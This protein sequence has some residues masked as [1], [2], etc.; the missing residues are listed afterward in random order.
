MRVGGESRLH[1]D[2]ARLFGRG[3]AS[4]EDRV[5]LDRFRGDGDQAAFAVL[6]ERHGPMVLGV[7]RRRLGNSHD[8]DDAFQA[9]FLVLVRNAGRL[10]N[11]DRLGP[12]LY[13]VA[14]RVSGKAQ[15]RKLR[16]RERPQIPGDDPIAREGPTTDL[17]DVKP[18]LDAELARV[19][20]KLRDVVILCLLEG[21][22]AEE[23]SDQ[24][25]CPLGTV[26]SRLARGREALR[27]RLT[28]RGVT[29]AVGFA[30]TSAL[31]TSPVP[32]S[33][34]RATLGTITGTSPGIAPGVATLLRGVA[35]AMI[36]KTTVITSLILGGITLAGLGTATWMKPPA[37][38]QQ[39][40]PVQHQPIDQT[41]PEQRLQEESMDHMKSL[42]LAFQNYE[43]LNGHLPPVAF[44]GADGQPKLS[45][46]VMLLP[47]LEERAL[48]KEFHLDEPWDSEHNQTL[49]ARMPSVFRTPDS[50]TP[51]G[52]TRFRGFTGQSTLFEGAR[53]F[54]FREV[55]DGLSHTVVIASARSPIVWTQPGELPFAWDQP[56]PLLDNSN[57]NW[58]L[59][60][61]AD[62]SALY[63]PSSNDSLLR[64]LITRAGGEVI[65]WPVERK[66][67]AAIQPPAPYAKPTPPPT[68]PDPTGPGSQVSITIEQRLQKIEEKV[69]RLLQKFESK[70]GGGKP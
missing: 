68:S 55:Y 8:A 26:K 35:P 59:T 40:V 16:R 64:R 19:S 9:T 43:S 56:L 53:G 5:L 45:W 58:C 49:I 51:E 21:L 62:G 41:S 7:C 46:R 13:G 1:E 34:L 42:M 63:V 65:D 3:A 69:D 11:A 6:V 25:G 32:G 33:L 15:A 57:P 22:T 23:A 54:G 67:M 18:I 50:P 10:Q 37:V 24:L 28:R 47:Y 14:S 12:W 44:Y 30:T 52:E 60:G 4:G 17:I 36:S 29:P 39:P 61:L 66:A 27:D 70:P 38:A 20:S 48:F 2:L 31:S